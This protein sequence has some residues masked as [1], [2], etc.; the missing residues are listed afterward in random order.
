MQ[1]NGIVSCW[2]G[3]YSAINPERS[4]IGGVLP[5]SRHRSVGR[6]ACSSA[7]VGSLRSSSAD[8][9]ALGS[10]RRGV[11]GGALHPTEPTPSGAAGYLRFGFSKF[12]LGC[13]PHRPIRWTKY[14]HGQLCYQQLINHV[15]PSCTTL[16]GRVW[17]VWGGGVLEKTSR[18][19]CFDE[20]KRFIFNKNLQICTVGNIYFSF[21]FS[22]AAD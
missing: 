4:L 5:P 14:V 12:Q 20:K 8:V 3:E 22:F 15:I 9:S 2:R 16:A 7:G 1:V 11:W 18:L 10:Q 21:S 6:F 13:R 17:L 19:S